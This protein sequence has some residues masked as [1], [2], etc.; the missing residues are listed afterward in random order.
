MDPHTPLL[1]SVDG[2]RF[3]PCLRTDGAPRSPTRGHPAGSVA[4][5]LAEE[6]AVV[7]TWTLDNGDR[8]EA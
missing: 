6:V 3:A 2:T 8:S 4:P 7:D 1:L 5:F